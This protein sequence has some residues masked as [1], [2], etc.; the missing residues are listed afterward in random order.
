MRNAVSNRT[1]SSSNPAAI[2]STAAAAVAAA[3]ASAATRPSHEAIAKRAYEIW[4]GNG[5]PANTDT[6]NWL[7]AE[8]QLVAES[9]GMAP[10]A[11]R[12]ASSTH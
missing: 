6:Q 11:R 7:E 1:T 8:R 9:Q 2:P 4:A 10:A 12:R 5:Y 3:A